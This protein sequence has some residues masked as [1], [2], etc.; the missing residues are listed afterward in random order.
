[1]SKDFVSIESNVICRDCVDNIFSQWF[2][3]LKT[4]DIRF[5]KI[6]MAIEYIKM[7]YTIF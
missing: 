4:C 5:S 7:F 3:Y 2:M 1:M 6:A